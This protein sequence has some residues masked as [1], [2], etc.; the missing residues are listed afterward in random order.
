MEKKMENE[1]ETGIICSVWQFRTPSRKP[2]LCF[3]R[4]AGSEALAYHNPKLCALTPKGC[5][6]LELGQWNITWKLM[7]F[8]SQS[9]RS[10]ANE[11]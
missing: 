10:S 4:Y 3:M 6:G 7:L 8:I 9:W 2:E 5:Y 1:M 11:K